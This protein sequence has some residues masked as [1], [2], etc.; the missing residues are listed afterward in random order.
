MITRWSR[1]RIG[2][3]PVV[4]VRGRAS[5]RVSVAGMAC[6][7]LG[8]WS[9]LIYAFCALLTLAALA[10]PAASHSRR[11]RATAS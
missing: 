1:G 9:R 10:F 8:E 7:K 3:T 11:Q 2:H 4:Q 6:Y 5:G